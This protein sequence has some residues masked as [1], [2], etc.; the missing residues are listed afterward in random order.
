[1]KAEKVEIVRGFEG[2]DFTVC[3]ELQDSSMVG[4]GTSFTG[5]GKVRSERVLGRARVLLVP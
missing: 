1:M 3:R 4:K 2:L 5:S